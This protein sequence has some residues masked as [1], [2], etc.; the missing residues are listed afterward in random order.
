[1]AIRVPLIS[2]IIVY[3]TSP[4]PLHPPSVSYSSV[5]GAHSCHIGEYACSI[6]NPRARTRKKTVHVRNLF[7]E[8]MKKLS[9]GFEII[10]EQN[11]VLVFCVMC[12]PIHFLLQLLTNNP[13]Q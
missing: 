6:F 4:N 1:M 2:I 13:R 9:K 10:V 8:P 12:R 3:T 7:D 5:R 11:L